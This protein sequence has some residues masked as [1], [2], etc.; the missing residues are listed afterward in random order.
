M[1]IDKIHNTEEAL[2]MGENLS[3]E[4]A[5]ELLKERNLLGHESSMRCKIDDL[6]G[7]VILAT[8]AQ[9]CREA[10]QVSQHSHIL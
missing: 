7:A 3:I 4:Q 2:L 10:I 5:T 1:L 9:F 6:N 8:K